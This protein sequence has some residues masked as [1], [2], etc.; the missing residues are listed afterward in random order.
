M[1]SQLTKSQ[2]CYKCQEIQND[3]YKIFHFKVLFLIYLAK[4]N[5]LF[6]KDCDIIIKYKIISMTLIYYLQYQNDKETQT[7]IVFPNRNTFCIILL[8][9]TIIQ[10]D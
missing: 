10:T 7:I 4:Q 8:N 1:K 2:F 3:N 9:I 5:F 6:W